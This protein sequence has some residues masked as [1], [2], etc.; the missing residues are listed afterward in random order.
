M[1]EV[2]KVTKSYSIEYE[3]DKKLRVLAKAKSTM[4]HIVSASEL[5]NEALSDYI[6]KKSNDILIKQEMKKDG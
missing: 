6:Q 3:I 5:A 4:Q 1:S 2:I